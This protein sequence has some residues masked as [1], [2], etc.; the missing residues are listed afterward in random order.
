MVDLN[1]VDEGRA[2]VLWSH[3]CRLDDVFAPCPIDA[4][5]C[6][7]DLAEGWTR[8]WRAELNLVD[9]PVAVPVRD[10]AAV[11]VTA[12]GQVRWFSW[13]RRQRHRP[14][15]QYVVRTGGLHG[16]ESLEEA[17]LLLALDFAEDL[18]DVI[19]QPLRLIYTTADGSR[20]SHIPD[21]LA[22]ASSGFRLI[23]VRPHRRISPEDLQQFAAAA[24]AALACGWRYTLAAQCRGHATAVLN[25]LSS[26]RRPL[27]DPL[28]L[29]P[30]LME[31]AEARPTF[32]ELAASSAVPPVARALLLHQLWHRRLGTDLSVPLTD[33]S[34]VVPGGVRTP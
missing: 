9:G 25:T 31:R 20:R 18:R 23:D 11:P 7:L 29:L 16:F 32:G 26:Q 34:P 33:A 5:R 1:E 13:R 12:V 28:G 24:E 15:L 30:S 19:P 2:V 4:G 10:L 27:P 6:G 8:R 17:K 3:R 21:F 14:G 22:L